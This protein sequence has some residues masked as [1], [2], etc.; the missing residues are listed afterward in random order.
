MG[1]KNLSNQSEGFR[2][3]GWGGESGFVAAVQGVVFQQVAGDR[4]RASA[5]LRGVESAKAKFGLKRP[6]IQAKLGV[7]DEMFA[8]GIVNVIGHFIAE[9]GGD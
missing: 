5:D 1:L 6:F 9:Q 8:L 3:P 4:G 7:G 2:V